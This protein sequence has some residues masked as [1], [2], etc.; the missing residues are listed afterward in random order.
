MSCILAILAIL[1][2]PTITLPF[3]LSHGGFWL[4]WKPKYLYLSHCKPMHS[5]AEAKMA[6]MAKIH[7]IEGG[8]RVVKAQKS[9]NSG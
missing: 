7:D 2:T 8:G 4:R 9:A 5:K 6:K 1:A 3:W